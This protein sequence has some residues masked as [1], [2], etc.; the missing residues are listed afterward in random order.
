MTYSSPDR[1]A[2][3]DVTILVN[4]SDGFEDCWPPFFRL[5]DAQWPDCGYPVLLNTEEKNWSFPKAN[6]RA[7]RVGSGESRRLS[8]SECLI[9]A[10]DQIETPLLL[11]FQEDYF[12]DRPVRADI[13]ENAV[14]LMLQQ[15]DI[16]HIALTKQ[17]SFGPFEPH[18]VAG[19]SKIRQDARYRISTQA[20]LWRPDVLRSYLDPKE[21]GWMFEIFGTWRAHKRKDLF[22]VADFSSENGGPAIDYVHTGIIK[23]K[24]HPLMPDLFAEH[25]I[26]VDFTKR[27][28]YSPPPA[29]VRKWEVIKKLAQDPVHAARQLF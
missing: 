14:K 25:D 22:L 13:V 12:L 15:P 23:G 8:W 19:F 1:A 17:G 28:F 9:R 2:L 5:L 6:M 4:S 10:I 29:L 24:W 18:P 7:S 20:G 26:D 11:Y 27:G 3:S 21:N 16:G